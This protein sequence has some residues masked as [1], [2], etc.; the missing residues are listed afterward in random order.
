[1]V[2]LADFVGVAYASWALMV[3]EMLLVLISGV[4]AAFEVAVGQVLGS[5]VFS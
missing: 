1:M 3:V 2:D 4:A 5:C